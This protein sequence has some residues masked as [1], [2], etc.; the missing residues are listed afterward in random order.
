MPTQIEIP[1]RQRPTDDNGYLEQM[2]KAIFRAG[3]SWP[4]IRNK[5]PN[6]VTAFE[7]FDIGKVAGYDVPEINRLMS[8]PGIVRNMKKIRATIENA[9]ILLR[10]IEEH[11]SFAG[12]LQSLAHLRYEE[13]RTILTR[14]F[15]HLG[16]T[17]CFV[18]L[19]CVGA[20]V[21]SWEQR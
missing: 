18:F 15:R 1:P 4:V 3:F 9:R 20:E 14:T 11:G 16:H 5:W 19:Y 6:F 12:Y 13:R 7:E 17:G 21:P 10:I 8:D 2:T